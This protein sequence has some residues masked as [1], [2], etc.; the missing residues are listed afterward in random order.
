[1]VEGEWAGSGR[2]WKGSGRGRDGGGRGV[3]GG[4]RAGKCG[5]RAG[6]R[7]GGWVVV[8]ES[9]NGAARQ[10]RQ[11]N[12]IPTAATALLGRRGRPRADRRDRSYR[13]RCV[14]RS[15]W[16]A[17]AAPAVQWV[18]DGG[19]GDH[20]DD[21]AA[22]GDEERRHAQQDQQRHAAPPS[23]RCREWDDPG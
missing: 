22:Q 4:A 21:A 14:S 13:D 15:R 7:A 16:G 23:R 19:L 2:R 10:G 9:T 11:R 20:L 5:G 6:W 18:V 12:R 1:M 17:D 3:G 8:R